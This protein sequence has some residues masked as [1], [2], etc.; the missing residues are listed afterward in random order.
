MTAD[1]QPFTKRPAIK[2]TVWKALESHYKQVS[3]NRPGAKVSQGLIDSFWM[4]GMMGGH[5]S[6]FDSS[7][8]SRKPT[9]PRI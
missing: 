5:T 8:P 7:R 3:T 4:Q 9:S 1:V 2:R 6:T